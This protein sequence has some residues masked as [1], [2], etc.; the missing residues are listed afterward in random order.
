[1]AS[2]SES[3][4]V[5]PLLSGYGPACEKLRARMRDLTESEGVQPSLSGYGPASQELRAYLQQRQT[6]RP[7]R[8]LTLPAELRLIVYD[9][10]LEQ[11]EPAQ[12]PTVLKT[13]TALIQTCRQTSSEMVPYLPKI[14]AR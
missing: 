14:L 6:L 5:Q 4:G 10:L 3:Q 7:S 12:L 11:C 13:A 8:Y 9:H 2:N 1:M